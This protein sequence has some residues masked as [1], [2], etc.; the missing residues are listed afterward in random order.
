MSESADVPPTDE[1]ATSTPGWVPHATRR[2]RFFAVWIVIA[3][4]ILAIF[5]GVL[6]P[7]FLAIVVAYVLAPVV[8]ALERIRVGKRAMP[9]WG[10]VVVVYVALL[11]VLSTFVAVGVP[12]L[13]VEI[14]TL[15]REAPKAISA[16]RDTWLPKIDRAIR[17]AMSQY[18]RHGGPEGATSD[19]TP[20]GP[21]ASETAPPD[22]AGVTPGTPGV[23]GIR[24]APTAGGG[25]VVE[26]PRSGIVITPEGNRYRILPASEAPSRSGDLTTAVSDALRGLSDD[27][28]QHAS[29]LLGAARRIAQSVVKGVFTFFIMLMISAYMLITKDAILDFFRTLF[30]PASRPRFDKLLR[31][32]D[33]GLG[34]V[35]RGQLLIA[36]VNG[37]LSGIGFYMLDLE[38][39][40]ILTLIATLLS[41]IPI[42]GAILSSIP[43]VIVG[44][45]AS[46]MTGF[47]TLVWIIVIHQIEA[48]LLNPKIMGDAAKVHPVL[49]VFALLAGEHLFGIPG[50]LLAVPVL[51]ITQTIFLHNRESALGIAPPR[52]ADDTLF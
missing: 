51:S 46:V 22:V 20:S 8:E 2:R 16:A 18:G 10:A 24:V 27:T 11:A 21:A 26:L 39:W 33:R 52:T 13:A 50:A 4:L 6:L 12:R 35:V 34:G 17:G 15:A 49:V 40:P 14:Q 38:Y 48:N 19:A 36:L 37:V 44:L 25:Y 30:Q 7:F 23:D 9:R 1:A 5:R 29:T 45:Q 47:L 32:L 31:R 41:I 43:A 3:L 28:G 42:F